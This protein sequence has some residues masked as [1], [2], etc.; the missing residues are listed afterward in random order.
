MR[1]KKNHRKESTNKKRHAK[2]KQEPSQTDY[3]MFWRKFNNTDQIL[4]KTR[5]EITTMADIIFNMEE[6]IRNN[7]K[8]TCEVIGKMIK[9]MKLITGKMESRQT[10]IF[11]EGHE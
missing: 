5:D 11:R 4:M 1:C 10:T 9:T 3:E 6:K 2:N 7:E 8:K